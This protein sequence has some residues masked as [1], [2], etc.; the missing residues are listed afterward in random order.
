MKTVIKAVP[1]RV[2]LIGGY[3]GDYISNAIGVI[4]GNTR[5]L[6]YSPFGSRGLGMRALLGAGDLV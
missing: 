3:T 6:D 1:E 5:S 4:K 2:K